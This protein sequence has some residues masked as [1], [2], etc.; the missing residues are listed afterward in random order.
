MQKTLSGTLVVS[1]VITLLLSA[2]FAASQQRDIRAE[3]EAGNK[4]FVEAVQQGDA[5]AVAELY[6]INAM[7]LP[8]NSDTVN[9]KE[10]IKS[11][12]QGL[13]NS[14]VKG[15]TLTTLEVER[16]GNT[17][18]EVGRYTLKGGNGQTLDQGKYIV[19]WKRVNGQ[20]KLHRDI[21][22]TNLPAPTR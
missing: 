20:W 2:D 18:N 1:I 14:G 19:I 15:I 8:A 7:V 9:G 17:A 13:I 4:K 3:I 16:Y 12:F 5:T 11:L 22:N 10:A 6:T 21:F